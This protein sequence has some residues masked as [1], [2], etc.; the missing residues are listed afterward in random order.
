MTAPTAVPARDILGPYEVRAYAGRR[1]GKRTVTR[2]TLARWRTRGFPEPF[3]TVKAA[4]LWDRRAVR[5]WLDEHCAE[6]YGAS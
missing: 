2:A 3:R 5:A 4:E 6:L 1:L